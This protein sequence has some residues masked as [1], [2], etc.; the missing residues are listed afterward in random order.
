MADTLQQLVTSN[1]MVLL[2]QGGCPYC[3]QAE[4]GLDSAGIEYV[5]HE[6]SN[7]ERS[8]MTELTGGKRSVPQGFVMGQ[9]I[10]GCNDGA[11]GWM[12]VMP[13]LQ[14]GAIA[15]ALEEARFLSCLPMLEVLASQRWKQHLLVPNGRDTS[16]ADA[17]IDAACAKMKKSRDD[18]ASVLL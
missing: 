12:G 4:Q 5:K 10:G 18:L 7:D 8:A 11:E 6:L 14:S 16:A 2:V 3:R 13:N 17:A 1:K 15:K 9:H